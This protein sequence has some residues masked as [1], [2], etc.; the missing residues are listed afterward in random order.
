[1]SQGKRK[2]KRGPLWGYGSEILESLDG[3]REGKAAKEGGGEDGVL[4]MW[5]GM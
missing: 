1:M 3:R 4:F 5:V 2:G